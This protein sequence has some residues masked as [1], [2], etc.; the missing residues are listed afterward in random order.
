MLTKHIPEH[1]YSKNFNRIDL[2]PLTVKRKLSEAVSVKRD[3]DR[4]HEINYSCTATMPTGTN[5]L[6]AKQPILFLFVFIIPT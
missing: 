4:D 6:D 3:L 5:F 2:S 1:F